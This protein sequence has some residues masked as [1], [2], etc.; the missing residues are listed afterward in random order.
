MNT[1]YSL[2]SDGSVTRRQY[3]TPEELAGK[4]RDLAIAR[5]RRKE[6][7]S[8]EERQSVI[9]AAQARFDATLAA[10]Q[11]ELPAKKLEGVK[12]AVGKYRILN[13]VA[14]TVGKASNDVTFGLVPAWEAYLFNKFSPDKT[15]EGIAAAEKAVI[16]AWE[17]M[18]SELAAKWR[19]QESA[20]RLLTEAKAVID[21][22]AELKAQLPT[23]A[24]AEAKAEAKAKKDAA[25]S[26]VNSADAEAAAYA[27]AAIVRAERAENERRRNEL[28]TLRQTARETNTISTV[29]TS[30]MEGLTPTTPAQK[31]NVSTFGP[32][33]A[34]FAAAVGAFALKSA[35][36]PVFQTAARR[37]A[38]DAYNKA[39]GMNMKAEQKVAF[40]RRYAELT[41]KAEVKEAEQNTLA[42]VKA[43]QAAKLVARAQA[44]VD[45]PH[46]KKEFSRAALSKAQTW[47]GSTGQGGYGA[48]DKLITNLEAAATNPRSPA[49]KE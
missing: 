16:L 45:H 13:H 36:T 23:V 46:I 17:L 12:V 28:A 34:G 44:L 1:I 26:E 29:K 40:E 39:L 37:L 48:L 20:Q 9:D 47:A 14:R 43:E 30:G 42:T 38:N 7:Y 31:D 41:G 15:V 49:Y 27:A 32:W 25:E 22:G 2:N 19:K 18:Q 21:R 6:A 10:M 11:G 24:P 35:A 5:A 8:E 4:E 3:R 33:L